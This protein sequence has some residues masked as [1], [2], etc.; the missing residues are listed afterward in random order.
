LQSLFVVLLVQCLE[1]VS[2]HFKVL[3]QKPAFEC[4]A[5]GKL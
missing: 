3:K 1:D 4:P 5:S 2:G